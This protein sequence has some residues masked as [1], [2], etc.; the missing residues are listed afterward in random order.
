V[1]GESRL[2]NKREEGVHYDPPLRMHIRIDDGYLW[3]LKGSYCQ[4]RYRKKLICAVI[5]FPEI[6]PLFFFWP[7][8]AE[9]VT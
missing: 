1:T 7:S 6:E 4:F 3:G 8:W 5:P 2:G 9:G